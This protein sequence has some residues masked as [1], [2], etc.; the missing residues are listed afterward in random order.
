MP[1]LALALLFALALAPAVVAADPPRD[2]DVFCLIHPKCG[3]DKDAAETALTKQ[4]GDGAAKVVYS[5]GF[6]TPKV[7]AGAGLK[8][9]PRTGECFVLEFPATKVTAIPSSILGTPDGEKAPRKIPFNMAAF[10]QPFKLWYC[11]DADAEP[12]LLGQGTAFGTESPVRPAGKDK[13]AILK[14]P[15]SEIAGLG[16]GEM[17]PK[18]GEHLSKTHGDRVIVG[19]PIAGSMRITRKGDR[20]DVLPWPLFKPSRVV[21]DADGNTVVEVDLHNRLPVLAACSL[22]RGMSAAESAAFAKLP[23]EQQ[24]SIPCTLLHIELEPGEKATAR[25]VVPPMPNG[26]KMAAD[27]TISITAPMYRLYKR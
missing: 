10:E 18:I 26:L 20:E 12:E 23:K 22:G 19:K 27:S 17:H 16:L 11:K 25:F 21:A 3:L 15:L 5:L 8:D 7:V 24:R 9:V 14:G 1:R 13:I 2:P 4:P 6:V